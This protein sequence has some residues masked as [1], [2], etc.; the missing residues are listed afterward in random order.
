[1]GRFLIITYKVHAGIVDLHK[2][3][4]GA[5][6]GLGNISNMENGGVSGLIV[7]N[8]AHGEGGGCME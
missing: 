3:I 8:C 6:S 7:D 1:M 4:T 2:S 5:S